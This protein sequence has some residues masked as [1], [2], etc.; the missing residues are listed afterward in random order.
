LRATMEI[1]TDKPRTEQDLEIAPAPD[2]SRYLRRKATQKLRKSHFASRR[3]MGALRIIAKLGAFLVVVAFLISIL[4]YAYNSDRFA[5]RNVTFY[6]CKQLDAKR[7]EGIIRENFSSNLLRTDLN[8]V[9]S[10]LEDETWAKRVEIRR[11]LPAD[12]LVYVQE[13]V[14]SVILEMQGELVLADDDGVILD[15]Y[16]T[17]YGKLDVPVFRGVLGDNPEGYR[18]YQEENSA[19]IRLGQK[20]LSDLESGSPA[21]TRDISEVDLSDKSNLKVLLVDDTAEIFL[22][23][24]DF[25]KRF[26]LLMSN[27]AQYRELKS[28]YADIASV[29]LRFDGQI[30]YRPKRPPNAHAMP[31]AETKP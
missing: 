28:Q 7:L 6:G 27:L 10:L 8:Q 16:D 4:K 12:L 18:L 17:K 19:R 23:D 24:R 2:Q 9:R 11:V 3:L 21:Y 25:L 22:G 1:H 20:L 13:R 5:L 29:D 30:I 14:P 15:K 26:R 31:V